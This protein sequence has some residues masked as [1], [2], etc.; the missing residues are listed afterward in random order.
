MEHKS[1]RSP[2]TM[3]KNIPGQL[4]SRNV[5]RTTMAKTGGKADGFVY[6]KSGS[7]PITT[8]VKGC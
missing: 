3:A 8:N 1:G 5:I 4:T 7:R 2:S 6:K